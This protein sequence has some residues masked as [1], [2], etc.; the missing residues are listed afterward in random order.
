MAGSAPMMPRTATCSGRS[1]PGPASMRRLR[2][3]QSAASNTLSSEQAATCSSTTSVA[4][5][6]SLSRWIDLDPSA[7]TKRHLGCSRVGPRGP[8][9]FLVDA[10]LAGG[11]LEG[12]KDKKASVCLLGALL[13]VL[14]AAARAASL[15]D[16]I[17]MCG[18]CH[19][20]NGVPQEKTT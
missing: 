12:M 14:P 19:G 20:E 18:A 15:E 2:L 11:N 17:A 4:I 6:S 16:N 9:L 10:G 1:R 8:A 7:E 3:I 13:A 5:A